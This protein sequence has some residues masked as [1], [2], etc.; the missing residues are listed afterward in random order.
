MARI[1]L[2]RLG[3]V[4]AATAIGIGAALI[5]RNNAYGVLLVTFGGCLALGCLMYLWSHSR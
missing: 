3:I 1:Y 5:E 4:P 2:A